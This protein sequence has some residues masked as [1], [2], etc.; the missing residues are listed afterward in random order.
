MYFVLSTALKLGTLLNTLDFGSLSV[1]CKCFQKQNTMTSQQ[2]SKKKISAAANVFFF[3]AKQRGHC[4]FL[5]TSVF[6]LYQVREGDIIE[7]LLNFIIQ[8]FIKFSKKMSFSCLGQA[9]SHCGTLTAS[10]LCLI[11]YVI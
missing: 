10:F 6:L 8:T 11:K 2:L 3:F 9:R 5:C 7:G 4:W 1:Y